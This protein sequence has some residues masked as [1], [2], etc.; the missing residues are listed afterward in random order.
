MN[1]LM[2]LVAMTTGTRFDVAEVRC[3]VAAQSWLDAGESEA[4]VGG[5]SGMFEACMRFET[6]SSTPMGDGSFWSEAR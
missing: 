6:E 4:T 5:Q 3:S 1:V 2:L